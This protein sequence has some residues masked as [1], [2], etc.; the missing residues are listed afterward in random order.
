MTLL[1]KMNNGNGGVISGAALGDNM[2]VEADYCVVGSGAGGS[3]AAAVLAQA[4][5]QVVLVEEGGHYTRKDFNLQES[6]AYP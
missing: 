6:W 1:A 4:G 5:A 2:A 3:M